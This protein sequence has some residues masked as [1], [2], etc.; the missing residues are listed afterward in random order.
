MRVLNECMIWLA[1]AL[2]ATLR[3]VSE[4]SCQSVNHLIMYTSPTSN[5]PPLRRGQLCVQYLFNQ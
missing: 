4:N 2:C 5:A 3:L 1:L